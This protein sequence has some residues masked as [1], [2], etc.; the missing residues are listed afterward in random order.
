VGQKYVRISLIILTHDTENYPEYE[1]QLTSAGKQIADAWEPMK[2]QALISLG[3]PAQQSLLAVSIVFLVITGVSQYVAQKRIVCN[4]L[5]IFTNFASYKEKT[6]LDAVGELAKKKKFMRT[7]DIVED[8]RK[9]TG[10]QVS[11]RRVWGILNVLQEHGLV[12]KVVVSVD[13]SPRLVWA[14]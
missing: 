14:L 4:N 6:V 7:C 2:N 3:I 9:R 12:R 5:K 10:K 11:V 8:V 13:N 1:Q